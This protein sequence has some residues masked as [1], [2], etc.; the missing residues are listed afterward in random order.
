MAILNDLKKYL[1]YEFSSG[2]Y[3]GED[4]KTFQTKYINYLRSLCKNNNWELLNIGRNHYEFSA[5]IKNELNKYIY[6]SISDVRFWKNEWYTDILIRT[7]KTEKDYS[8]GYNNYT[9]LTELADNIKNLFSRL[10]NDR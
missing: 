3:T 6:L 4:Y 5:F 2:S 9:S 1:D 7:A 10:S 8:G